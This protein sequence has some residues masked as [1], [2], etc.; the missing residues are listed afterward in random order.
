M[1]EV[2]KELDRRA[3]I[4]I[5]QEKQIKELKAQIEKMKRCQNC[6]F[7]DNN[8]TEEPCRSCKRCLGDIKRVVG[9]LREIKI[10]K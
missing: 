3:E 9:K 1:T 7:E 2:E 5:R 10:C 4:I 6:K 8:Y